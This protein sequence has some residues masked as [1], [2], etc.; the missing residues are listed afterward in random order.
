MLVLD[1]LT[2]EL[3]MGIQLNSK[4]T[5]RYDIRYVF[6]NYHSRFPKT[7]YTYSPYSKNVREVRPGVIAMPNMSRRSLDHHSERVAQMA[8]RDPAKESYFRSRYLSMTSSI[9]NRSERAADNFYDSQ[10]ESDLSQF[11]RNDSRL[12]SFYTTTRV[13]ST[14]IMRRIISVFTTILSVIVSPVTYV[15]RRNKERA[16]ISAYQRV[17]TEQGKTINQ[18]YYLLSNIE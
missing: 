11:G 4:L 9:R 6:Y 2:F 16:H 15:I 18:F 10:D 13:T 1:I 17:Q 12:S 7:D 8:A 14:T 5:I 3:L